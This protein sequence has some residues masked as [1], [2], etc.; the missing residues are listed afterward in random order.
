MHRTLVPQIQLLFVIGLCLLAAAAFGQA[1]P[2]GE[3]DI[4]K[5]WAYPMAERG[6][7]LV[8]N[9]NRVFLGA[10]GAKVEALSFDGKK[11]WS[12]ELGGEISSNMLAL[13]SSLLLVTSIVSAD[14][15]KSGV[16]LL[17]SLSKETGITNW[18]VK[19]PDADTH[20][21][22][23]YNGS[24]IVVSKNGV[25]QSIDAKAGT[26]KW[27]REIAEGFVAQPVFTASRVLVAATGKQ[28]F[29]VSLS[30]GE[31]ESMRKAAYT[32]TS[33]GELTTGETIAGDDRGNVSRL[34]GTDKPIW[35]FKSGGGISNIFAYGDD[36]IATS[37]DNF[38][39]LLMGSNGDV[40]WK[41]RMSGRVSQLGRVLD[42]Y[43][44]VASIEENNAVLIELSSGKVAGQVLYAEKENLV[45]A[46]LSSN[47]L[48]FAL[49]DQAAYAYSLNGCSVNKEGG[50]GKP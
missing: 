48:I 28:I 17:R 39:Y 13:E 18:S 16:S 34:N 3:V 5:C 46:P 33:L 10:V 37:H 47:G 26:V 22:G 27:K 41:K 44:L 2:A 45:A 42:R 25:I 24:V 32:A 14:P 35:R 12:S 7:A 31:I 23:A 40:I 49:T 38:V 8:S 4:T 19:M 29:S 9:G 50:Q 30:S 1:K 11:I 21:I 43:A 36:I 6:S 15:Q 20:F